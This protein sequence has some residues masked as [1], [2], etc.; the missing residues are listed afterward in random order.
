MWTR[1]YL[2]AMALMFLAFGLYALFYPEVLTSG[3]GVEVGGPNGTFE[4]RGVFGGVSLGASALCGAGAL[5]THLTR[6]ALWFLVT[7]MG[8]YCLARAASV[9]LG[10]IPTPSTWQFV[11]FEVLSLVIAIWALRSL[12]D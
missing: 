12:P 10:D 2:A 6:P 4:I 11:A 9:A 8:G 3:L 5:R 1:L 7:Y